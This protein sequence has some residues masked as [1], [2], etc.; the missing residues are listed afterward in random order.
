MPSSKISKY[1][2]IF[3]LKCLPI[4]V[5]QMMLLF[6][7]CGTTTMIAQQPQ[8]VGMNTGANTV[9]PYWAPTYTNAQNV[10]YYYLPDIECYYDVW[11][12]D[13]VYMENGSWL[14]APQLP[15]SYAWYDFN[16]AFVVV[17][18][19]SIHLPWMHHRFYLDHYPR[20]YYRTT[21]RDT[22]NNPQHYMNGFNENSRAIMYRNA[23]TQPY[24]QPMRE[25]INR[26]RSIEPTRPAQK[27]EYYGRNL[28]QPVRVERQMMRPQGM[29]GGHEFGGRRG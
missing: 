8:P 7:S 1:P 18:D 26:E 17:L 25:P 27:V 21:Y 24:A 19:Y 28:G 4:I 14:F 29:R 20:Y 13:F 12:Q 3:Y 6:S 23:N 11:N 10:Q 5:I 2:K 15:P 22:Y 16:N 9:P